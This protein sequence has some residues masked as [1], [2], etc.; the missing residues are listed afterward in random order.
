MSSPYQSSVL[1]FVVGQY[2]DGLDR[3]RRAVRHAR[4]SVSLGVEVGASLA[5]VPAYAVARA[6]KTVQRKLKETVINR[7]LGTA[8]ETSRL[9]DFSDFDE[10]LA[11][12]TPQSKSGVA[13]V[14]EALTADGDFLSHDKPLLQILCAVGSCLLPHQ[15]NAL[16]TISTAEQLHEQDAQ[17]ADDLRRA[18]RLSVLDRVFQWGKRTIARTTTLPTLSRQ[19]RRPIVKKQHDLELAHRITGVAS[20]LE[21]RSL[22]LVLNHER[23]WKGLS[24][25]QQKKLQVQISAFIENIGVKP[26]KPSLFSYIRQKMMST[27]TSVLPVSQAAVRWF[28]SWRQRIPYQQP[29]VA[30]PMKC[31]AELSAQLEASSFQIVASPKAAMASHL[32]EADRPD[33]ADT[34]VFS[35]PQKRLR[36]F[37]PMLLSASATLQS[38]FSEVEPG[39]STDYI[40]ADVITV[41]Y[42]EHPLEKVLKWLDRLLLWLE[43]WWRALQNLIWP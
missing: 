20:D 30:S 41:E 16:I 1:R 32:E 31:S 23:I 19:S 21:T 43:S 13:T 4:T 33:S 24:A 27:G 39:S 2:R 18:S 12:A 15:I 17:N 34:G 11:I 40:E 7:S 25:R 6:A 29:V 35:S 36:D 9:L 42:I 22:V 10:S 28:S 14:T 26:V 8:S 38:F 5:L 37:N 3:H